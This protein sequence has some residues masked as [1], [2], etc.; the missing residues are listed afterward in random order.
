MK[1]FTASLIKFDTAACG[2]RYYTVVVINKTIT[3]LSFVWV[4]HKHR[5]NVNTCRIFCRFLLSVS[6]SIYLIFQPADNECMWRFRLVFNY[7]SNHFVCPSL[8]TKFMRKSEWGNKELFL[9]HDTTIRWNL[10]SSSKTIKVYKS[11]S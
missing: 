5:Q 2:R 9:H 3:A 6:Q 1:Y 11:S 7:C 4:W 10:H 8:G